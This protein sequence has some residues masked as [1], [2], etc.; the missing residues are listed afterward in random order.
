MTTAVL[1]PKT[2]RADRAHAWLS[3][4]RALTWVIAIAGSIIQLAYTR[5]GGFWLDDYWNLGQAKAA[6]LTLQMIAQPVAGLHFQPTARFLEWVA[7]A[8]FRENYVASEA[9]LAGITG[10]GA[11]LLVRLLDTLFGERNLHLVVGFLFATSWLLLGAN[12]WYSAGTATAATVFSIGACLGFASWVRGRKGVSPYALALASSA[13]AV[14]AWEQALAIPGW[15]LL[16]WFCYQRDSGGRQP[17][18][19]ILGVLPFVGVSLAYLVYIEVQ[20][21]HTPLVIPAPDQWMA[22]GGEVLF[23]ALIPT[24][25]GSGLG[26]PDIWQWPAV[27]I[28]TAALCVGVAWLAAHHRFRVSSIL[29]LLLGLLLVITPVATARDYVGATDAGNT[30]RYLDFAVFV[31]LLGIAGAVRDKPVAN[32]HHGWHPRTVAIAVGL[33]ILYVVNLSITFSANT[34]TFVELAEQAASGYTAAL[35]AGLAALPSA[36]RDSVVDSVLPYPVWYQTNNG[37]AELS[38]LLPF[39][40]TAIRTFGEGPKL[41]AL[42]PRGVLRSATFHPGDAGLQYVRVT[43]TA[44]RDTVLTVQVRATEPTQPAV[45]WHIDVGSGTHSFT[46]PAW[47][48]QVLSVTALGAGLRVVGKQTGTLTLGAVV[49]VP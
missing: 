9:L 19:V 39:W 16:I 12:Q 17:R 45:R 1:A 13:I 43:V 32:R 14:M 46:V 3:N 33:G 18:Q 2:A 8:P 25:V 15:L 28:P 47:S 38:R 44:T 29:F 48:N 35:A 31:F 24:L 23:H 40:S 10:V 4:R 5:L 36:Q 21:W 20:P 37:E 11:Y 22:L 30:A 7:V 27:L 26:D 41:V 34:N 6:G 42:D 49:G